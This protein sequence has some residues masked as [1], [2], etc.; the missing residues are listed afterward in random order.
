MHWFHPQNEEEVTAAR[1]GRAKR[2]H[3]PLQGLGL[4]TGPKI[5]DRWGQ[6]TQLSPSRR[7]G[8][9]FQARQAGNVLHVASERAHAQH[10]SGP[11]RDAP[12]E[13]QAGCPLCTTVSS[14]HALMSHI[15]KTIKP[16][17]E[18]TLLTSQGRGEATQSRC[19]T[20]CKAQ[21]PT[22]EG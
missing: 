22:G 7:Q 18:W 4:H 19:A 12:G 1:S 3:R 20:Y 17:C 21:D 13:A 5:R 2:P 14:H 6:A 10:I 15:R 8:L 16:T 9:L 11:H